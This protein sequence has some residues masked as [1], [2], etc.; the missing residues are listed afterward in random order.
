M[1]S[2]RLA[3]VLIVAGACSN[4]V[5]RLE[6]AATALTQ[7]TLAPPGDELPVGFGRYR[8]ELVDAPPTSD[9]LPPPDQTATIVI[10]PPR[11]G[12][13]AFE[14]WFVGEAARELSYFVVVTVDGALPIPM[15]TGPTDGAIAEPAKFDGTASTSPEARSLSY[16]WRLATRPEASTAELDATTNLTAVVIP[17]VRGTYTIELRVFDGELW[18][19]PTSAM[20]VAR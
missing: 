2:S 12:I 8:W 4:D 6:V 13:Y 1:T 9:L 18:S 15:L 10:R 20:L 11:R 3:L 17:D 5:P 14:R 19:A 16:E 7:V